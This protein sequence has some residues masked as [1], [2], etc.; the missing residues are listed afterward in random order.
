MLSNPDTTKTRSRWQRHAQTKARRKNPTATHARNEACPA[1]VS[2]P[3]KNQDQKNPSRHHVPAQA[4]RPAPIIYSTN[5]LTT[6]PL[7]R[8]AT[9]LHTLAECTP[10]VCQTLYITCTQRTCS[11]QLYN[12]HSH[13]IRTNVQQ[14]H[15]ANEFGSSSSCW[16]ASRRLH[17]F[18]PLTRFTCEHRRR[19]RA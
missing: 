3:D 15:L 1:S 18:K 7:Y 12:R 10:M 14:W 11:L 9:Q 5:K 2:P 8:A 19:H 4:H 13:N 6:N 16:Q 17:R